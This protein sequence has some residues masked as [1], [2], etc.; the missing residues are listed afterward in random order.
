MKY[1]TLLIFLLILNLSCDKDEPVTPAPPCPV[2]P[3][4]PPV[5]P[6][7]DVKATYAGT[8]TA[9]GT[10][11]A[12]PL[13]YKLQDNNFAVGSVTV[14]GAA[15]TFGGYRNT[16]D[17]VIISSWYNGNGNYYLLKG[18]LSNNRTILS[19]TFNN[20]TVTADFGTFTLTRQ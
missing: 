8:A 16:C 4:C 13:V 14:G 20:L 17:S 5:T 2:C 15:T 6:V 19:G 9:S 1:L 7:C 3:V 11:T 10:T 12:S 18:I